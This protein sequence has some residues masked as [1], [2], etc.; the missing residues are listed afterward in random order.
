MNFTKEKLPVMA[1]EFKDVIKI[2]DPFILGIFVFLKMEME[3]EECTVSA[4]ID[5]IK[6][7]FA[8]SE[9]KVGEA[10]KVIIHELELVALE[11]HKID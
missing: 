9:A 3:K 11:K 7:H 4:V 5:R 8:I 1:I 2:K 6:K 10:L